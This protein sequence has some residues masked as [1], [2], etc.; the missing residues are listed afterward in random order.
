MNNKNLVVVCVLVT[1]IAIALAVTMYLKTKSSSDDYSVVYLTSGEVYVGK[2]SS[3]PRLTMTDAY[4][5]QIV[6]DATDATKSSFQLSPL[7]QTI[8]SPKV[9]YINN[10]QVIFSGPISET[11]QVAQ[12]IKNGSSAPK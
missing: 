9:L 4:L 8:W 2:L 5:I 12:T 11:S 7:S 10:D 1:V 6:K 3:F